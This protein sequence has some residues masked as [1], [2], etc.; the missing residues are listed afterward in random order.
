MSLLIL[1][2]IK[3]AKRA[4]PTGGPKDSIPPQLINANPKLNTTF[5]DKEEFT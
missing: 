3:C 2:V 4:T 1:N 5:F